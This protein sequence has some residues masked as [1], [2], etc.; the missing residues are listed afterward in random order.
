MV[1][2]L[3]AAYTAGILPAGTL[4]TPEAQFSGQKAVEGFFLS[5]LTCTLPDLLVG[6]TERL[7]WHLLDQTSCNKL[8]AGLSIKSLRRFRICWLQ[9]Y[10]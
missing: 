5:R 8:K 1:T 9:Q 2:R 3:D 10:S 7:M 6:L 4:L